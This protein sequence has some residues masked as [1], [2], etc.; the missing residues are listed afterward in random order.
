MGLHERE[1]WSHSLEMSDVELTW[2]STD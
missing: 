2:K 1:A